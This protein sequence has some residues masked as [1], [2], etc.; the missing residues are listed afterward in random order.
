MFDGPGQPV[1][2]GPCGDGDG[3]PVEHGQFGIDARLAV[4][5]AAGHREGCLP[6]TAADPLNVGIEPRTRGLKVARPTPPTAST[7][8]YSPTPNLISPHTPTG[9]RQLVTAFATPSSTLDRRGDLAS[10]TGPAVEVGR[11]GRMPCA[12]TPPVGLLPASYVARPTS[13]SSSWYRYLNRTC[14]DCPTLRLAP[15]AAGDAEVLPVD[16]LSDDV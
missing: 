15:S 7:C 11:G 1:R 5:T 12:S 6:G 13:C 2:C 4:T 10:R 16:R 3:V 9:R 8:D 14:A